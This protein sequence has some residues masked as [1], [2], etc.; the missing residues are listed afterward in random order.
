MDGFKDIRRLRGIIE[1]DMVEEGDRYKKIE[2]YEI[3]NIG[4]LKV[5]GESLN[6]EGFDLKI[7][8]MRGRKVEKVR[9]RKVKD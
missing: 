2:G 7:E 1:R 4:N 3:W 8:E 9:I 6:E 5:G